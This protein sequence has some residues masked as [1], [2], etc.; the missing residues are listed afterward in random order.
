[1]RKEGE[2]VAVEAEAGDDAL[3]DGGQQ[4]LV[5]EGFAGVDVADVD[6]DDGSADGGNGVG[7]GHRR[8]GVAAGIEHD[9][10]VVK[11]HL[12]QAVHDFALDVA[13]ED[14]NRVLRKLL[15]EFLTSNHEMPTAPLHSSAVTSQN[16]S[17]HFQMSQEGK[18]ISVENHWSTASACP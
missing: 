4:W 6:L 17:K 2:A 15:D 1:M 11:A 7:D 12:L 18:S 9:G 14:V 3:A 13:L 10:A 8:V 5:A 16:G